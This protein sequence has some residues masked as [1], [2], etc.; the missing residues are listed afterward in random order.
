MYCTPKTAG[1]IGSDI[2]L[3]AIL[4]L[5]VFG[6]STRNVVGQLANMIVFYTQQTEGKTG[7]TKPVDILVWGNG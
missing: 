5:M 6:S 4:G 3:S 7:I 2:S 1:K